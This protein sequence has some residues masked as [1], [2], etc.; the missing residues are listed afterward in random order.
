MRR[1]HASVARSGPRG[2]PSRSP[3][4][5]ISHQLP[6]ATG[7]LQQSAALA[8]IG[9]LD[10]PS[11]T[12][13]RPSGRKHHI[14]QQLSGLATKA[15]EI[16]G[17]ND[18]W[19]PTTTSGR[20]HCGRVIWDLP[21]VEEPSKDRDF[22]VKGPYVD[23]RSKRHTNTLQGISRPMF[24]P[25]NRWPGVFCARVLGHRERLP[26][27]SG[28]IHPVAARN[29]PRGQVI[30][31]QWETAASWDMHRETVQDAGTRRIHR[32]TGVAVLRGS[33]QERV[34]ARWRMDFGGP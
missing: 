24:S 4:A 1:A 6:V 28:C 23:Q 10:V 13:P 5:R 22:P 12:P 16:C 20:D 19:A 7:N 8:P 15:G 32:T 9:L 2:S 18:A 21:T 29:C 31:I 30:D 17:L 25:V 33:A 27:L 11:S 14:S 26:R 3:L 34:G